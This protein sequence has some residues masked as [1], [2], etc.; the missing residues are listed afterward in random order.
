[1]ANSYY[2]LEEQDRIFLRIMLEKRYPKSKITKILNVDHST[3]CRELK[4]NGIKH[5]YSGIDVY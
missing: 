4:R 5:W 1:M 2:H 3:I